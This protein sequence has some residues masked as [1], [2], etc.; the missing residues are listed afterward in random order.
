M[1]SDYAQGV[2]VCTEC[3]LQIGPQIVSEGSEWRVFQNEGNN[4]HC[5]DGYILLGLLGSSNQSDPDRVGAPDDG[6][7]SGT[8][9]FFPIAFH[10]FSVIRHWH[11]DWWRWQWS[12]R[13]AKNPF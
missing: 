11:G 12:W 13:L 1:V 5:A 6:V 4:T 10:F 7:I 2:N 8:N 9:I 3:G